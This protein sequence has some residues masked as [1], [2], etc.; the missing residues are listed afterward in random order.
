MD[1]NVQL[2]LSSPSLPFSEAPR[3]Q[4]SIPCH[5]KDPSSLPSSQGPQTLRPPRSQSRGAPARLLHLL[6]VGIRKLGS[7]GK[8]KQ[9]LPVLAPTQA[10]PTP[11]VVVDPG[12]RRR[13]REPQ[14][15]SDWWRHART[16]LGTQW[17]RLIGFLKG[18]GFHG[19]SGR[20]EGRH[21]LWTLPLHQILK[22]SPSTIP[23]PSP[24]P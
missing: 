2:D 17:T 5:S 12:G 23:V 4:T 14:E 22:I 21:F 3:P 16:V 10:V 8:E 15:A 13:E 19:Q 24:A 7:C 1:R 9:R 11:V 18:S 6:P 20:W